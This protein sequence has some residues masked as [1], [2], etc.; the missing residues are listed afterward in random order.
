M[1]RA[2]PKL[3]LRAGDVITPGFAKT[4]PADAVVWSDSTGRRYQ[5]GPYDT[6]DAHRSYTDG[7]WKR[8]GLP[9]PTS[10]LPEALTFVGFGW[11]EGG[12]VVNPPTGE[13]A[14]SPPAPSPPA[15]TR[16][17]ALSQAAALLTE[18]DRIAGN[19]PESRSTARLMIDISESWTSLAMELPTESPK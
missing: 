18:A 17:Y 16:T 14:P 11:P 6:W 19:L 12:P 5:K 13:A 2:A 7:T 15:L 9:Y 8:E 10:S 1:D 4:L 3:T